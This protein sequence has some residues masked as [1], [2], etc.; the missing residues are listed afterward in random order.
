MKRI[1]Y[2]VLFY[3]LLMILVVLSKPSFIFKENNGAELKPFGIGADKTM[4][5]F[6]V[7]A[8]VM[9]IVSFYLFAVID[10]IFS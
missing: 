1:I 2:S 10:M 6:G 3:V 8:V 9:A 7:F 5:S 4:F